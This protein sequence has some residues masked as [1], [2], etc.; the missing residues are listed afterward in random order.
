MQ[1]GSQH[2]GE[3]KPRHSGLNGPPGK[4]LWLFGSTP[5]Q[6]GARGTGHAAHAHTVQIM[7]LY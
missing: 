2:Q 7:T 6:H 3:Y 1:D 4:S 5:K